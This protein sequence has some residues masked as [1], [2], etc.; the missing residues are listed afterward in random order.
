MQVDVPEGDV[1]RIREPG[2]SLDLPG[3]W[4]RAEGGEPGSL[5]YRETEGIGTVTVMLLAVRPLYAIADSSRLHS[6]YMQ[7]RS[8]FERGQRPSLQQSEPVGRQMEGSIDGSWS[9]VDVESGR[10]QLHRVVLVGGV[11]ADFCYEASDIDEAP[12]GERASLILDSA[13]VAVESSDEDS[14]ASGPS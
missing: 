11:L 7:H 8:K 10:R 2:F 9:A 3:T 6:D 5:V 1:S 12:F 4:E 13:K 14:E